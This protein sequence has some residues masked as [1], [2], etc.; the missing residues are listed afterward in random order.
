MVSDNGKCFIS[1]YTKNFVTSKNIKWENIPERAA[2]FG[3]FYER[4]VAPVKNCLKKTLGKARLTFNE[5]LTVLHEVELILN[6]KPLSYVSDDVS[7]D[8]LTPN[9]VLFG[10]RLHATNDNDDDNDGSKPESPTELT[11]RM[12][13]IQRL[14]GHF[15]DQWRRDYLLSLREQMRPHQN[16]VN[17]KPRV[18]DIVLIHDDKVPRHQWNTARIVEIETSSDGQTRA[19]RVK[20]AKTGNVLRRPINR[21]YPILLSK[22]QE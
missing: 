16:S 17:F 15:W 22:A 14:I 9:H 2:W 12:K 4:I 19:A 20:S 8:I 1:Q 11:S 13:Y 7:D 18:D 6:S 10:R 3:G 21:L 5:L